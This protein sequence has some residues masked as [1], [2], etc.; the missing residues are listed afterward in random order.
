MT[1]LETVNVKNITGTKLKT[2]H[3]IHA[4][5]SFF[6]I[7]LQFSV[8]FEGFECVMNKMFPSVP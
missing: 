4:A 7:L 3:T 6:L 1:S 8:F 2:E 5:N